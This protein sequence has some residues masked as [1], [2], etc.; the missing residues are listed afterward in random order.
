[1]PL[2]ISYSLIKTIKAPLREVYDWCTDFREDDPEITGS[3]GKYIIVKKTRNRVV[4]DWERTVEGQYRRT[5]FAVDLHPPDRWNVKSRDEN[6]LSVG[7]YKLK[8]LENST[9]LTM[10]FNVTVDRKPD[11]HIEEYRRL[12][13]RNAEN[14]WDRFITRLEKDVKS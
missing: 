8:Q 6:R 13:L 1:M 5:R 14:I 9:Q 2:T 7:E 3:P 12:R 11:V 4:F 10:T